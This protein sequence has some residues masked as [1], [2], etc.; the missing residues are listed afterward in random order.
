MALPR[1]EMKRQNK[2][3]KNVG[4]TWLDCNMDTMMKP[5]IFQNWNEGFRGYLRG[6]GKWDIGHK[7]MTVP[8]FCVGSRSDHVSEKLKKISK[9]LEP[10]NMQNIK[11]ECSSQFLEN[12]NLFKGGQWAVKSLETNM[13]SNFDRFNFKGKNNVIEQKFQ[14]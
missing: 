14:K 3:L 13:Y 5:K 11:F 10:L 1:P 7:D 6:D 2:M 4:S 8:F 12:P 9:N